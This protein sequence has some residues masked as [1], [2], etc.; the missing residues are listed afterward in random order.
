MGGARRN[1]SRIC[2]DD[3]DARASAKAV[4]LIRFTHRSRNYLFD[5]KACGGK[6]EDRA[7]KQGRWRT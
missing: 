1:P 7:R 5:R 2:H 6:A 4:D 3:V